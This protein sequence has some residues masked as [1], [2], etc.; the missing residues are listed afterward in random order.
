MRSFCSAKASHIFATKNIG[1]FQIPVFEILTKRKLIMLSVLN[2]PVL[3]DILLWLTLF[4]QISTFSGFIL[5][6][7][8]LK[9]LM[10]DASVF[11][12]SIFNSSQTPCFN[13]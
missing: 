5:L 7:M 9:T 3:V 2:N 6:Y 1:V 10:Y 8:Y 12:G 13:S 4:G 11:A